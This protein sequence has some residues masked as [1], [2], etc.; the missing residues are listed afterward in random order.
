M[1]LAEAIQKNKLPEYIAEVKKHMH[2]AHQK[3]FDAALALKMKKESS[4][5]KSV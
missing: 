3:R 1:N 4:K 2:P 5:E